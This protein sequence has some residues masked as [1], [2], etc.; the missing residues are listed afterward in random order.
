[1]VDRGRFFFV[2]P[3]GA[4]ANYVAVDNVGD[5]LVRCATRPEAA[6]RVYPT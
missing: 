6:G 4:S 1:V 2:G 5:A 3:P